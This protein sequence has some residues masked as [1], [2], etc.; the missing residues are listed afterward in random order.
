MGGR[1]VSA[2]KHGGSEAANGRVP[3]PLD[4]SLDALW[5]TTLQTLCARAAHD[6]RGAL[7]AVAVNLEVARSRS[8]KPGAPAS[9]VS[10][11]AAIA[12]AQLEGVIAMTEALMFLVRPG[13]GPIDVG[14][15]VTRVA[16]LLTPSAASAGRT[17]ELER[18][19]GGLGTTS[20]TTSSARLAIGHCLLAA[21]DASTAV[22]CVAEDASDGPQL[23]VQHGAGAITLDSGVVDVLAAAGIEARS[24]PGA[25]V[26]GFP[27]VNGKAEVRTASISDS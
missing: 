8:E 26:I 27:R 16:A 25:I 23:R 18:G 1:V 17:I 15:E 9:V 13:R 5:L 10:P 19:L 24:E 22:R 6:V 2:T 4:A 20:A 7:N 14:A 3:A 21:S 12:S 11:Y